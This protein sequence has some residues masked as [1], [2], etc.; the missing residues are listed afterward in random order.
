VSRFQRTG[1]PATRGLEDR[2]EQMAERLY[3]EATADADAY[4]PA[5]ASNWSGT[6]PSTQGEALQRME[7]AI[8]GLLGGTIP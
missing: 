7:A 3:G 8:A 4:T 6:P 5:S 1:N 2:V